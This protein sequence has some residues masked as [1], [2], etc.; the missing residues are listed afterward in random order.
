MPIAGWVRSDPVGTDL[1]DSYISWMAEISD[2][3]RRVFLSLAIESE[4]D[5]VE[6]IRLE[7]TQG[8]ELTSEDIE[9]ALQGLKERSW[10]EEF[11]AGRWQLTPN[12]HGKKPSMLKVR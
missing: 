10:A 2:N 4:L 3:E 7:L 6:E 5:T 9:A 12:G 1:T 8:I 11:E